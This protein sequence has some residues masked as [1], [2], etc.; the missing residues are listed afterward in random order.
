MSR[1][2]ISLGLPD[3]NPYLDTV[4]GRRKTEHDKKPTKESK[5]WYS[6]VQF[7]CNNDSGISSVSDPDPV[8]NVNP[9]PGSKKNRDKLT[10]KSTKIIRK[11]LFFKKS[12]ILLNIRE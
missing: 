7:N 9:D 6:M 4:Q 5:Q 10:K 8:G 1:I 2:R 3:P 11:Q 12:I